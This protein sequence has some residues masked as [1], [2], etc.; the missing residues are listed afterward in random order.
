[1]LNSHNLRMA[2]KYGAF[3]HKTPQMPVLPILIVLGIWILVL[4]AL[5]PTKANSAQ[6]NGIVG[7][8]LNCNWTDKQIVDAI[9]L[10]EG[11]EKAQYPYGIRSVHCGSRLQCKRC[12][13]TTVRNNR[14]RFAKYGYKRYKTYLSFLQS[15]YCP[16][17]GR[18]LTKA[19]LNLNKNWINNVQWFLNHPKKA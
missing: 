4:L 18:T 11:G 19:E 14:Y 3:G 2:R 12:C 1:M 16:T 6:I 5:M 10:A 17:R 7:T 15:S 8:D 13:E 9:Y